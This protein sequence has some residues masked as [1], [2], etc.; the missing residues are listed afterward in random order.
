MDWRTLVVHAKENEEFAYL[1]TRY[2]TLMD[3]LKN[4]EGFFLRDWEVEAGAEDD[5]RR[6]RVGAPSGIQISDY[7][8]AYHLW[9]PA[10][11]RAKVKARKPAYDTESQVKNTMLWTYHRLIRTFPTDPAEADTDWPETCRNDADVKRKIEAV[12]DEAVPIEEKIAYLMELEGFENTRSTRDP[13]TAESTDEERHRFKLSQAVWAS[14][15]ELAGGRGSLRLQDELIRVRN[16]R[17]Q[18]E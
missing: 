7:L 17:G 9:P 3:L 12:A 16:V 2:F 10:L 11:G 4:Q 1:D 8:L 14:R 13:K 5:Y 18:T 6:Y 15:Y